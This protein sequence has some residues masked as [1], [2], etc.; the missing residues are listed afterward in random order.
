MTWLQVLC[1]ALAFGGQG[2]PAQ[3]RIVD[4]KFD[5]GRVWVTARRATLAQILAAWTRTGKTRFEGVEKAPSQ[6]PVD[7]QLAGVFEEEALAILLRQAPGYTAI[8]RGSPTPAESTFARV[9]IIG[10]KSAATPLSAPAPEPIPE[11]SEPVP[12]PTPSV[13]VQPAL[14]P[15]GL[16]IPDDQ[17]DAPPFRSMPPGFSPPPE[18]PPPSSS[19]TDGE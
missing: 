7:V 13:V 2:P 12:P 17:Q 14:G 4:L 18:P 9:L 15:D 3:T 10:P 8:V 16:P 19:G 1:L 5:S 11:P 6:G